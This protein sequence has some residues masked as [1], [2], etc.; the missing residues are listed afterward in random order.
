MKSPDYEKGWNE[1][2]DKIADYVE[3]EKIGRAHV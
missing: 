1:A 3:E 2:F